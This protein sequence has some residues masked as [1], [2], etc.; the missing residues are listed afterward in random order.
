MSTI[1][2]NPEPLFK[3][4][5]VAL[6]ISVLVFVYTHHLVF[7]K[8]SP[9]FRYL[10]PNPIS[11]W[12]GIYAPIVLVIASIIVLVIII[13]FIP[14]T[15]C[16]FYLSDAAIE[17]C[18]RN[19]RSYSY[20][21][22]EI[23]SALGLIIWIFSIAYLYQIEFLIRKNF[24]MQK[25]VR[26]LLIGFAAFSLS[27]FAS[28]TIRNYEPIQSVLQ[29]FIAEN[30]N[31]L[32]LISSSP[33]SV[34]VSPAISLISPSNPPVPTSPPIT[35][36][37][38]STPPSTPPLS[39]VTSK[40]PLVIS[41]T[42]PVTTITPQPPVSPVQAD[43]FILATENALQASKL[44]Q[45]AKAKAEWQKVADRWESAVTFMQVVPAI[46]PK[47]AIAQQKIVEYQANLDYAK[48][49]GSRAVN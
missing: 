23:L 24:S 45:V 20:R 22:I 9:N 32:S 15:D 14:L 11:W 48:L 46:H 28:F 31:K 42:P 17:F 35:S 25:F 41:S 21:T 29:S 7:G 49:G 5:A 3:S 34:S 2:D 27:V 43:P 33:S 8:R 6:V 1:I 13:P 36:A 19:F 18:L 30:I 47:Y 40:T 16:N 38:V 10:S 12:Q 39:I 37:V 26:F 4:I 44:V